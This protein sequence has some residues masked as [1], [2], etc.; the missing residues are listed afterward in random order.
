MNEAQWLE[1]FEKYKQYPE[2]QIVNHRMNLDEFKFI[3]FWEYFHR[4]F[5]RLIGLVFF[6]PYAFFLVRK[7][8]NK[9]WNRR[10]LLGLV[11]GGSQGLLGWFMVKSGLVERPD[12]S[13]FRLAAH[14]GLALFIMGYLY[15][16]ILEL[17]PKSSLDISE[18]SAGTLKKMLRWFSVFLGIQIIYGAFVAGL[19]AGVGF[20][21]FPKMGKYWI[22]KV[23]SSSDHLIG[24]LINSNAG[25]QF[26]HRLGGWTL[27]AFAI[28]FIIF[29]FRNLNAGK[30][31]RDIIAIAILIL[32]Q[33]ALGVST[34][35][36][37][38]AI[39][40]ASAHQMVACV[41]TLVTIKAIYDV[42]HVNKQVEIELKTA[43]KTTA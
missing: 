24:M 9:T 11:L 10:L 16:L 27:F 21:T 32:F 40:F 41:L 3:F 1:V 17:K 31:R 29:A 5:G 7:K 2:Y 37:K 22:P 4:L 43:N 14:F 12:V 18:Q 35:L 26:V 15:W 34:L 28:A 23:L 25:V 39:S 30:V 33:F 36:T 19:D 8:L 13:H 42:T 20:N 38:V 6:L